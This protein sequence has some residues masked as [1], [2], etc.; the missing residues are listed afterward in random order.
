MENCYYSSIVVVFVSIDGEN[1]CNR[2]STFDPYWYLVLFIRK[3]FN[4]ED[5]NGSL[6]GPRKKSEILADLS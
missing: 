6:L 3:N 4:I 5:F 1:Y 2:E